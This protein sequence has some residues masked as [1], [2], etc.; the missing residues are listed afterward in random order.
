[1]SEDHDRL[2]K[3]EMLVAHQD[4]QIEELSDMTTAQWK[5][6]DFLKRKIDRL[7]SRIDDMESG[8][9][10]DKTGDT[11][12]VSEMAAAEKPPHY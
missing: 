8:A 7:M 6:I 4:K 11:K 12:S 2:L 3:L 9:A 10:D 1:M 5:E